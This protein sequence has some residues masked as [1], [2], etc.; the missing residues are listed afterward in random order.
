MIDAVLRR[1]IWA[2]GVLA[3]CSN[4]ARTVAVRPPPIDL[5]IAFVL[6]IDD[7][8]APLAI[9]GPVAIEDGVLSPDEPI[10]LDADLD[11]TSVALLGVDADAVND[12]LRGE[13]VAVTDFASL[14]L[15]STPPPSGPAV[16]LH[17]GAGTATLAVPAASPLRIL[18]DGDRP[19]FEDATDEQRA[20][21]SRLSLTVEVEK[22]CAT[23]L[24]LKPFGRSREMFPNADPFFSF[25]KDAARIDDD[26][27]LTVTSHRVFLFHRDDQP[28]APSSYF[29][30][31]PTQEIF[32]QARR[33]ELHTEADGEIWGVI[34]GELLCNPPAAFCSDGMVWDISIVSLP[35]GRFGIGSVTTATRTPGRHVNA[36]AID[37][38]GRTIVVGQSGLLLVR[39]SRGEPFRQLAKP[40]ALPF[41]TDIE[42]V[43]VSADPTL[44]VI[45]GGVGLIVR[46]NLDTGAVQVS[47]LERLDVQRLHLNDLT[48]GPGRAGEIWAVSTTNAILRKRQEEPFEVV[49]PLVPVELERCADATGARF[50]DPED[51]ALDDTYAYVMAECTGLARYTLDGLCPAVIP[52]EGEPVEIRDDFLA[53]MDMAHGWL[54]VVGWDGLILEVRL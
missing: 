33:V 45:Y 19:A 18:A 28:G 38:T 49:A 9:H 40:R 51:V 36:A 26:W 7:N 5:P 3:S 48:A 42:R 1:W 29:P 54:T 17:Q 14:R 53:G 12:T 52:I 20:V 34:T 23:N 50:N 43:V 2:L 10:E 30:F 4:D 24:Q 13:A 21:L 31:R 44:P 37:E 46:T 15:V 27:V 39:D 25:L 16:M 11:R 41:D 35:D 8:H 6:H 47:N 32:T 22:T